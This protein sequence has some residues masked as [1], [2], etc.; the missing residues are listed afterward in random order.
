MFR[1]IIFFICSVGL[2]TP[3]GTGWSED[4]S[5][6]NTQW[7]MAKKEVTASE[8][9]MDPVEI[10]E[11]TIH[12]KTRLLGKNVELIY[13][14]SQDQLAKAAYKLDDNYLNSGHFLNTYRRFKAALTQKY[15]PPAKDSTKW[16]NDTFRNVSHKKG[17]ALSLGHTE[18]YASWETPVSKI[19]L[20][21]E[22]QN[23]A[24]LCLIEY[25]SKELPYLAGE[26]KQEDF[27]KEDIV[28]P[29]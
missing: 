16:L 6:R 2:L 3:A 17:L 26:I 19:S 4:Y 20:R 9:K 11:N 8:T 28:D 18:Y 29:F 1:K 27:I 21:L 25:W 15:G 13:L 7:G 14:F 12:Y 22:G 24:V 10:N 5:F 23:Y